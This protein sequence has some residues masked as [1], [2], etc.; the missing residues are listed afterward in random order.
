MKINLNRGVENMRQNYLSIIS[1]MLLACSAPMKAEAGFFEWLF[2]PT[3]AYAPENAEAIPIPPTNLK[4][5]A[6]VLGDIHEAVGIMKIIVQGIKE[7]KHIGQLPLAEVTRNQLKD[8]LAKQV[9]TDLLTGAA[10]G[11]VEDYLVDKISKK[12]G[13]DSYQVKNVFNTSKNLATGNLSGQI[14]DSAVL[15]G[16]SFLETL[17]VA[18]NVLP[19]K[20]KLSP[21]DLNDPYIKF[22]YALKDGGNAVAAY[23]EWV[24]EAKDNSVDKL[25]AKI[26]QVM[27]S[28]PL[29]VSQKLAGGADGNAFNQS[30]QTGANPC[31]TK[32]YVC[33]P[34]LSNVISGI[35]QGSNSHFGASNLYTGWK[36][37]NSTPEILPVVNPQNNNNTQQTTGLQQLAQ[38]TNTIAFKSSDWTVISGDPTTHYSFGNSFGPITAPNGGPIAALNNANVQ[39]TVMQKVFTI[40]TGVKQVTVGM[41]ANFVT[42]EYPVF[43]GSQYNDKAVIQITTGSGNTYQATLFN[44][45]L[46]SANFSSVGSLPSPMMTTGGQTG[47]ESVNKTIPVANGGQLTITVK[48]TN[49]GDTAYPSATLVNSTS[50]K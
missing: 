5:S 10:V 15:M 1:V 2:V 33:S 46:N 3:T 30:A 26:D 22:M 12:F 42:N 19:P 32:N 28:Q 6:A 40:P 50:V 25:K 7:G 16:Q 37:A 41:M 18:M 29:A 45:E 49:V 8:Q 24:K 23:G 36:T 11:I 20:D 31:T 13:I 14:V 39:E 48:T 47:F 34:I 43:V 9:G 21:N 17:D 27:K 4:E 35:N 44:K 38:S